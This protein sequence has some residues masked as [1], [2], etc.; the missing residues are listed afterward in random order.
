MHDFSAI[1]AFHA[2]CQY[3]SLTAAAKALEQPK[4]TLSRRLASL[5][6]DLGQALI[7]RQG[8]RLTLTKAGQV[9]AVYTKQLLELAEKSHEALQEFNNQISGEMTLVVHPNL[10]R[11]WLSNV[12]DEFM[13]THTEINIRLYSQYVAEES[14][15]EPDLLI[16]I[17]PFAQQGWRRE[18]LGHWQYSPYA[19]PHYLANNDM[20]EHPQD[21]VKHPWIDFIAFRQETLALIHP[22]HGSYLLPALTSRL[23]SDNLAMQADAIAKGRGI[24]LLPT[25]FAKGFEQAHPNSV[26]A[27]LPEWLSPPTEIS[28]HYPAGRH[29]LKLRL[30]IDALRQACPEE[31]KAP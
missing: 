18:L 4:S 25:W 11:G 17:G 19:S 12:L 5:E 7:A 13:Q 10:I 23:Q 1:K 21:L 14:H 3:K 29:P 26:Q 31:W 28:C 9:F 20:P 2:L 30:F 22:I 16:W 27:C 8:N 24:G 6:N 15:L